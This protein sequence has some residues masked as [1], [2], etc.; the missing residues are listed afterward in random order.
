MRSIVQL[1]N[2]DHAWSAV[3][4][5]TLISIW[6]IYTDE[7]I[8]GDG[9]R[10]IESARLFIEQGWSA[11]FNHFHWPLYSLLIIGVSKALFISLEH[12]AHVLNTML[13][14]LLVYMFVRCARELGGDRRVT[15]AA[16]ILILTSVTLNEFRDLIVRDFGYLACSFTA[17]W[18]VL[19]YKH[20]RVIHY[21]MGAG[22]ALVFATLFRVEG[23]VFIMLMPLILFWNEKS[24]RNGLKGAMLVWA[25]IITMVVAVVLISSL[26]MNAESMSAGKLADSTYIDNAIQNLTEGISKK[27]EIIEEGVLSYHSRNMGVKSVIAIIITIMLDDMISAT[28][29]LVLGLIIWGGYR[30]IIQSNA[31]NL[32]IPLWLIVINVCV[33]AGFIISQF[34]IV[35]RYVL[36]FSL[37]LSLLAS[38]PLA[39]IL[40]RGRDNTVNNYNISGKVRIFIIVLL[41]YMLADGLIST[42]SDKAYIKDSAEWLAENAS[43]ANI[44]SNDANIYYYTGRYIPYQEINKVF[45]P[46][47]LSKI[48]VINIKPYDYIAMKIGR[49]QKGYEERVTEWIGREPVYV[50]KNRRNDRI[51]VFDM[52]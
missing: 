46:T 38:F 30:R 49:K 17:L 31:Q 39:E 5:G 25:P 16:A 32:S 37:L 27:A 24:L 1:I 8:N 3:V 19:R 28:G 33:I 26:V 12:G 4:I 35:S 22:G 42:K 23:I 52:K 44:L 20:T 36:Y 43:G 2:R 34:F 9:I 51:L 7:V 21:A 13:L 6:V 10:Y 15:L 47:R 48:P 50:A 29:W 11:G 14:G 40:F 45:R 41:T 18:L